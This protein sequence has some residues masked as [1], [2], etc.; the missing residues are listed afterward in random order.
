MEGIKFN[1]QSSAVL[2]LMMEFVLTRAATEQLRAGDGPF[3]TGREVQDAHS[4]HLV[5]LKTIE[6]TGGRVGGED[7][8][9]FRVNDQHGVA[10]ELDDARL[11][12]AAGGDAKSRG[13]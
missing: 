6:L 2:A 11:A 7:P 13:G 12:S 3:R 1:N 9:R 10:Q 8:Q 4:E 5:T